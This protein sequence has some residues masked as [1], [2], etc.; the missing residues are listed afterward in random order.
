MAAIAPLRFACLSLCLLGC[1]CLHLRTPA[2]KELGQRVGSDLRGAE[3]EIAAEGNQNRGTEFQDSYVRALTSKES[4]LV[5]PE[6]SKVIMQ[7]NG[8]ASSMV[9]KDNFC[10]RRWAAKCPDG[11]TSVGVDQCVAPAAYGGACAKHMSMMDTKTTPE[12]REIAEDCK[13]PWPCEDECADGRDYSELC[14]EGWTSAGGGFCEASQD[15]NTP[16]SRA[17]D[18]AEMSIQTKSELGHTCGFNWKCKGDCAQDFSKSCPADWQE[19]PSNPGTCV[20]P[21]T[22]AGVCSFSVDTSHMS[23]EQKSAFAAKCAVSFG[24]LGSDSAGTGAGAGASATTGGASD[25]GNARDGP[26][27]ISGGIA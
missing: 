10:E 7:T 27:Q 8:L 25:G 23:A 14:P 1:S 4:V 16:C 12:K 22:Y 20:A 9:E 13:A 24:C 2:D 11:W 19:V 5:N 17:Y 18:F 6:V 3:E 15:S 26:V 21:V